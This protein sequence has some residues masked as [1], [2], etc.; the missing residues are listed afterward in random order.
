[1]GK[2]QVRKSKE[3]HARED[4]VAHGKKVCIIELAIENH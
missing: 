4:L 1:M 2:T 3:G